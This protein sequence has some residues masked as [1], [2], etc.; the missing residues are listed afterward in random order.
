MTQEVSDR[1]AESGQHCAG[2]SDRPEGPCEVSNPLP[3]N[4]VVKYNKKG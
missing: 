3:D 2:F 4:I 1:E